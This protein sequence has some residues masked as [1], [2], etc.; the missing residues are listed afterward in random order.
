MLARE[1][2]ILKTRRRQ[3]RNGT[4]FATII[5][6]AFITSGSFAART[7]IASGAS[8]LTAQ[9][10]PSFAIAAA[11]KHA[12]PE[13]WFAPLDPFLRPEVGYGGSADFMRLFDLDAPWATAAS[14]VRVF[15]LYPQFMH[16][17]SDADLTKVIKFL[18]QHQIALA[19]EAGLI[20][21][22]TTCSRTE[23]YGDDQE[24]IAQRIRRL[25]G[26]LR[27]VM[28]DEPLFFGHSYKVPGA[29]RIPIR[30]LARDA[31]TS[32]RVFQRIFPDVRIVDAE[33]ISNFKNAN[34]VREI[35]QFLSAFRQAYGQ[36]FAAVALDIAWWEPSWQPRALAITRYLRRLGEPVAVIYN[37]NERDKSDT[38]WLKSARK[39]YRDYEALGRSPPNKAIFQS[40]AAYPTQVL[41][42]T[43]PTSFTSLILDYERSRRAK[44]S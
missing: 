26:N 4:G 39:H 16:A 28:A 21:P 29:C 11:K 32:A 17:A 25:G 22:L 31:A 5:L 8:L 10:V 9:L 20:Q 44:R 40:W 27:Y 23:G 12:R 19:V 14:F 30:A 41:P 42:E 33:P 34:W 36:P 24:F 38:A 13:I 18:D 15:K 6:I 3:E 37:G 7:V 1:R 2:N 43:S 35:G